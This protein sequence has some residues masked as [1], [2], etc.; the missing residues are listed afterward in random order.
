M[1]M[2]EPFLNYESVMAAA[3]QLHSRLQLGGR[4]VTVSTSGVVPRIL[5]FANAELQVNLAVSL[6]ASTDELRNEL[7][8]LNKSYSLDELGKA[9]AYYMEKSNRKVFFEY[10]MLDG[11]NDTLEQAEHMVRWYAKYLP[12]HLIHV[13]LI[14]Y[15]RVEGLAY[16]CSNIEAVRAFQKVLEDAG[17]PVTVRFNMGNDIGAACGQLASKEAQQ[18]V[19]PRRVRKPVSEPAV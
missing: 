17:Y 10:V 11:V 14:P 6:H 4:R 7:V 16:V 15:N 2:G 18:H 12:K 1:G 19:K 8:P 9:I 13:N 5:D 3:E